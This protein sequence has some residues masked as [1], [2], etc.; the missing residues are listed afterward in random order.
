M[1]YKSPFR[2]PLTPS[3]RTLRAKIAAN[4]RWAITEDR[5]AQTAPATRASMARFEREVDPNGTL[6]LEERAKRAANARRAYF[7][8]LALK[9]ARVRRAR[10][11][12]AS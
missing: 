7:Q 8:K 4:A 5:A 2:A 11:G 1:S 10:K 3:Q 12:G 6:T 9:S